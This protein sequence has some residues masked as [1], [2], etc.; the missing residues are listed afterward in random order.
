MDEKK[1]IMTFKNTLGNSFSITIDD[2]REDLEE[3]NI[4]DAMNLIKTK[5]IFQPKGYDIAECI[6]AKV[7]NSTTTEYDLLV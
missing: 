5:N 3:Q 6:S 7:V 1:L 4:I 2:P